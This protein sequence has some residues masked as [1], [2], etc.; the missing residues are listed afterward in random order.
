MELFYILE[1]VSWRWGTLIVVV[2]FS[3]ISMLGILIVRNL[4]NQKT[5]RAHHDVAGFVFA[6]L[7]VLYSVLLGFTV[8][9]V[10]ARFEK[11]AE[12][13]QVEASY[14]ADLYRDAEVFPNETKGKIRTAIKDFIGYVIDEEW[15]MMSTGDVSV[16][17]SDS[18]KKIWEAYA[19]YSPKDTRE[20]IWYTQAV[21]KLNQLLSARLARI[22]GGEASLGDEMW[23]FLILGGVLLSVFI[24]FFSVDRLSTHILLGAALASSTAFLL[25]LIYTL[26]T[27]YS[28]EVQI[29]PEAMIRV[30]KSFET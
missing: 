23:A 21:E 14:L 28:G 27:A 20:I 17:A 6:N 2:V 19:S 24:C 25:F 22:M 30:L 13:T 10:Q 29:A 4:F 3:L 7:G 16:H 15:G 26:D 18:F 9:N 12:I 5:L 11:T 1:T 8:V